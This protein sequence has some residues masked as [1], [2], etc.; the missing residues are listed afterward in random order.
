MRSSRRV[1]LLLELVRSRAAGR[2]AWR[3]LGVGVTAG[4]VRL[5]VGERGLRH[6]RPQTG[7]LGLGFEERT[8]LVGDAELGAQPLQSIAHVDQ[9]A[10]QQGPWTWVRAVY[11]GPAAVTALFQR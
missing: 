3:V 4:L 5:G 10:L 6:E 8:L 11:G 2:R 9:T 1:L 7:V